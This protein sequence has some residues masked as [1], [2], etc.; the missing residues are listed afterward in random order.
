MLILANPIVIPAYAD[1]LD[2]VVAIF[3]MWVEMR[4]VIYLL[5]RRGNE[6][7]GFQRPVLLANLATWLT[8]LV[9]V[10]WLVDRSGW[11]EWATISALELLIVIVEALLIRSASKGRF[12]SRHL[13]R[14]PLS[15]RPTLI[16]SLAGNSVSIIVS[17]GVVMTLQ[18]V[19]R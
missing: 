18:L 3:A 9:A 6:D 13:R 1:P 11:N 10:E 8:F 19:L 7:I 2:W 14:T 5:G 12:F 15:F 4:T 16:V 17:V